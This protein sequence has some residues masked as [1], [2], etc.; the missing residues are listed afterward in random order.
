MKPILL[1]HTIR[2]RLL[3]LLI[4]VEVLMLAVLVSN[5][6]RL[7]HGAMANQARLQ[8]EQYHPVLE[9][10]LAVPL[11]QQDYATVQTILDESRTAGGVD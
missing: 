4:G 5:S 9:A 7:L 11:A 1:K 10:A 8:A 2:V 6:I 3:M